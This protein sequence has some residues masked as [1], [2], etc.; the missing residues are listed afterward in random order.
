[1]HGVSQDGF[2]AISKELER[3]AAEQAKRDAAMAEEAR[4]A[5]AEQKKE[6]RTDGVWAQLAA[7]QGSP[8]AHSIGRRWLLET[9]PPP[10]PLHGP[11]G[12]GPLH[13]ACIR[14]A[15][16]LLRSAKIRAMGY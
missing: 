15:S 12:F 11:I 2:P 1:M 14:N 9:P 10:P 4:K 13:F 7:A 6:P 16:N 3:Q 8:G 5:A